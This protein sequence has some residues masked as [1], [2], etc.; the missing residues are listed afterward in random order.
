VGF[1]TKGQDG[2]LLIDR[3]LAIHERAARPA[4]RTR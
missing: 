3:L 2:E 1:F 4:L